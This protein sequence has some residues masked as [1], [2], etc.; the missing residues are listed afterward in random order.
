RT[1]RRGPISRARAT[2]SPL[3]LPAVESWQLAAG[4]HA[5]LHASTFTTRP[6]IIGRPAP[7]FR[8]PQ[9]EL[10]R[11]EAA[12]GFLSSAAGERGFLGAG[13]KDRSWKR[14]PE[15]GAPRWK[16]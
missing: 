4:T 6:Q 11:R 1:G 13:G 7:I 10:P 9:A 2:I 3:S 12:T 14:A 15:V 5:A 16:P 8:I